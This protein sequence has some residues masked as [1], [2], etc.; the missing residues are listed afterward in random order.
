MLEDSRAEYRITAVWTI[1]QISTA[2]WAIAW[3][4]L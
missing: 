4:T 1:K 3:P 2:A